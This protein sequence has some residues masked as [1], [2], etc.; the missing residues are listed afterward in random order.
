MNDCKSEQSHSGSGV[1][2]N[3]AL[4]DQYCGDEI[5]HEH[6]FR[7]DQRFFDAELAGNGRHVIFRQAED[8]EGDGDR[9]DEAELHDEQAC[10]A[11][12]VEVFVDVDQ[13]EDA[14]RKHPD[15]RDHRQFKVRNAAQVLD[16]DQIEFIEHRHESHGEVKKLH[17]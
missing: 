13:Q 7:K 9:N 3:R 4:M 15:D 6:A 5:D 2:E 12:R 14:A 1:E 11:R 16:A 8:I 17:L 10:N